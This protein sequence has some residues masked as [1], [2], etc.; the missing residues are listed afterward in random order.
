MKTITGREI[1][2][3]AN[4]SARTF[5]IRTEIAKYRT[6]PMSKDEFRTAL[7]DTAD[8]WQN[9]LNRTDDYYKVK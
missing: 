3:K 2:V 4:Y 9:F 8:D 5:T 7:Y 6:H 1:K